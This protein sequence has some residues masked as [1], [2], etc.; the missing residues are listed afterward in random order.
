[1]KCGDLFCNCIC[2]V[3]GSSSPQS[4][5]A[6]LRPVTGWRLS[7]PLA[8]YSIEVRQRLE[9]DFIGDLAHPQVR[10]EQKV[11][12][13]LDAHTGQIISE[14]KPRRFLEHFTK[15]ESARIHRA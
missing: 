12:G 13:L 1:M 8:K 2:P 9:A 11:F 10:I 3:A 6:A 15:I 4:S 7:H 14:V 5:F